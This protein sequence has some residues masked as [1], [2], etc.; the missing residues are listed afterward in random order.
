LGVDPQS[1]QGSDKEE[2]RPMKCFIR[3]SKQVRSDIIAIY[4][5]IYERNPEAAERV[6]DA[7]EKSIRSLIDTPGIGHY[8]NST[9]PRL[10]GI[11][12]TSVRPFR[13]YLIFFRESENAIEVFR[14]V[15]GA[16]ELSRMVD[17]MELETERE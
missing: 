3:R 1:C 13:Q 6:L 15:H 8:W 9:D 11:K 2:V 16:R 10:Q 5:Y 12:V 4:E 7:I 14:V 17:E